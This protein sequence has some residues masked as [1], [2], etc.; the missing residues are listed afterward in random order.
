MKYDVVITTGESIASY[1]DHCVSTLWFENLSRED[2]DTLVRI[3]ENCVDKVVV[4]LLPVKE[5]EGESDA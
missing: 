3:S 2:A 1:C 4:A 5:S